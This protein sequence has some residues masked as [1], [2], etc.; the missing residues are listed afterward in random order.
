MK[1][2]QYETY[3]QSLGSRAGSVVRNAIAAAK[4]Q[5][6]VEI[7]DSRIPGKHRVVAERCWH[8]I[9]IESAHSAQAGEEG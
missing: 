6:N 2:G 8:R 9:T 7:Y 1:N 5:G 3:T 4:T